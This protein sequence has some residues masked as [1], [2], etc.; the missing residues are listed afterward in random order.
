MRRFLAAGETGCADDRPIACFILSDTTSSRATAASRLPF[1]EGTLPV[2]LGLLIAG[3]ASYAFFIVGKGALG[4]EAFKPVAS[5][6][7]LTFALSP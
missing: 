2:G 4:E 3:V 5:L 1:P 6:W 7:F